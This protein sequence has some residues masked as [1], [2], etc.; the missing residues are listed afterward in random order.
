MAGKMSVVVDDPIDRADGYR[1][2]SEIVDQRYD[3]LFVRQGDAA[4]EKPFGPE[5]FDFCNEIIGMR[6]PRFE[7]FVDSVVI[8]RGV[9]E[10]GRQGM[11]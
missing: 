9:L 10:D 5:R 11:P 1:G 2:V 4:G 8:E 7:K 6:R 3:G